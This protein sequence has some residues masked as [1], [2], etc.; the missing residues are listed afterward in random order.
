MQ[1]FC[2]VGRWALGT[3]V[4][5]AMVELRIGLSMLGGLTIVA[6]IIISCLPAV[7]E[8]WREHRKLH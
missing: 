6:I 3:A 1:V 5:I 4:H 7:I 8:Y 2:Q